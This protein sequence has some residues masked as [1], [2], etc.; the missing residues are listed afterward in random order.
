MSDGAADP[1]ILAAARLEAAVERLAAALARTRPPEDMV[2][3][4]EVDALTTRLEA[5]IARLKA[6]LRDQVE[7]E[8]ETEV[9]E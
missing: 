5:T 6:A 4:A 8:P 7:E 3:R 2:P 9:Q 1:V